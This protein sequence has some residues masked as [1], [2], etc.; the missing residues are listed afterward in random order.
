MIY[1]GTMGMIALWLFC[2]FERLNRED[3]RLLGRS[4]FDGT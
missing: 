1:N 4:F 2:L 3:I